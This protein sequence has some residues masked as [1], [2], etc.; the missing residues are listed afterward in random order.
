M[1][2]A[3]IGQKGI[4]IGER[5]GGIEQ[6]V[7]ALS[8]HLGKRGHEVTVYARR[9]YVPVASVSTSRSRRNGFFPGVTV[10]YMPTVYRKNLEAIVHT[11]LCTLDALLRP[12]DIIHY[13]GVGPSTLAWIPRLLKPKARVVC[14]FHSQDRFH[15][16]WGRFGRLY[17]WFGEWAACQFPHATIAVSHVIQVYARKRYGRQIIYIP[18]GAEVQVVEATDA[19]LAFGLEPR[20]YVLNVGR[21]VP[22]KGIQ[23]LIEAFQK[24]KEQSGNN[25]MGLVIVGAATYTSAYEKQLR[26]MAIGRNDILFLGYQ[27]G[28]AL[29]QLYAHAYLYVQPSESEGLPVVVLEAMSFGR[30]VLVSDI[31]ENLEAMRRAGFSFANK[32]VE[33]LTEKLMELVNHPEIVE[34]AAKDTQETVRRHFNWEMIAVHTEAVYLSI[35]H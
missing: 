16:K 35:R 18:N 7:R 23:Y 14:T 10:R 5:G 25:R 30:P 2:I 28:E 17:L 20:Q 8:L 32:S 1:R 6:H 3:M 21:L 29:R 34:D 4:E 27:S 11:F 24:M 33:D 9:R 13:H 26:G 22:H 19:V 15:K 31:P 12:Y